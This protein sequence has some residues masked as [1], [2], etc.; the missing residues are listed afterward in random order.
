MLANTRLPPRKKCTMSSVARTDARAR[1][2]QVAAGS[3]AGSEGGEDGKREREG[4]GK[5]HFILLRAESVTW[6]WRYAGRD[7]RNNGLTARQ[8]KG[9]AG[10]RGGV[11]PAGDV[12]GPPARC[13]HAHDG[14]PA[15]RATA[16]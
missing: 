8:T 11:A 15:V 7:D 9:T 14:E 6:L 2:A 13:A 1:P 10:W 3:A 16:A 12:S 5:L 4:D